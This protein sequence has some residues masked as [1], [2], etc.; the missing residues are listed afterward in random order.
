MKALTVKQPWAS[1]IVEGIKNIENRTWKTNFR[2]RILIHA[3]T[4]SE[5]VGIRE[6]EANPSEMGIATNTYKI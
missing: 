1:L 6:I 2:G 3:A 4:Q 5:Y